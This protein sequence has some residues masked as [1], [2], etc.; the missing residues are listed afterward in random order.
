[1]DPLE[2]S[3]DVGFPTLSSR[4]NPQLKILPVFTDWEA[5]SRWKDMMK[6]RDAVTITADFPMTVEL[7]RKGFSGFVI[8]PF[9]PQ[10][11]YL[12]DMFAESVMRMPGYREEMLQRK[13]NENHD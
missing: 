11:F 1:M 6:E 9:G 5:L 3:S 13:E 8:N 7:M 10:A 2:T 4:Q 12:S